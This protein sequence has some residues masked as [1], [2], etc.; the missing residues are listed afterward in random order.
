MPCFYP[1]GAPQDWCER[2]VREHA[3]IL[4][5]SPASATS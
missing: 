4:M 1:E 2:H 5:V 3:R